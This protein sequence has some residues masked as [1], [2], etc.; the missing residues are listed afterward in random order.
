MGEAEVS[1][2]QVS[3][4]HKSAD[5]DTLSDIAVPLTYAHKPVKLN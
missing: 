1:C 3:H 4:N 2:T 5:V